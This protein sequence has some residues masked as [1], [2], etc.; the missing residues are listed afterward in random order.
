MLSRLRVFASRVKV[1]LA[2]HA[3]ITGKKPWELR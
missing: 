3:S 1:D 2:R